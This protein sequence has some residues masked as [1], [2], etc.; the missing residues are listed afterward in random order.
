MGAP[1]C[2]NPVRRAEPSRPRSPNVQGRVE[3]TINLGSN[4]RARGGVSLVDGQIVE[5]D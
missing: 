2:N 3:A 1:D 5:L 4:K